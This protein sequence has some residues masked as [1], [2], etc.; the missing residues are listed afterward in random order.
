MSHL[1]RTRLHRQIARCNSIINTDKA[2]YYSVNDSDTKKLWQELRVVKMTLPSHEA[3]FFTQKIK[4]I[5]DMFLMSTTTVAPP[6][7]L[8]P[9]LSYLSEVSENEILKIIKDSL[10]KSCLLDPVPTFLLKD[11]LDI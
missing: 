6:M 2:E 5:Q 9:N 11:C 10:T 7:D 4:M 8:S 1:V 3:S